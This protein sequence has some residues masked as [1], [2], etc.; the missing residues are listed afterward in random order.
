[1]PTRRFSR[2][3]D[4]GASRLG[5]DRNSMAMSLHRD[6]LRGDGF[7]KTMMSPTSIHELESRLGDSSLN[8]RRNWMRLTSL[9]TVNLLADDGKKEWV[10]AL[11]SEISE[12]DR[13][14]FLHYFS[15]R[16]L[17]LGIIT[18]A[19]NCDKA[20]AAA[21]AILGMNSS[22]GKVLTSGP[23]HATVNNIS[24]HLYTV[25][26]IVARRY[27]ANNRDDSSRRAALVVRGFKLQ[28]ECEA[29]KKLLQDPGLGDH[30]APV[31]EWG[32]P[33]EWKFHLSASYWLLICLGSGTLLP[34]NKDDSRAM[35]Q[36]QR[37]FTR[38]ESLT[39][40]R[41]RVAGMITWEQYVNGKTVEDTEIMRLMK[42]LIESADLVC[43]TP[44]LAHTEDHLS[45]WKAEQAHGIA[46]DDA[47]SMSR[48]DLYSIWGNTLLPCLLTGDEELAPLDVKSYHDRD[49]DGNMLNRFGNDAKKSALEFLMATGW[50]VYRLGTQ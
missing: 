33:T 7:W 4:F 50:P 39:R 14:P 35:H 12:A 42:Q 23:T 15:K 41:H 27:N 2:D 46:I 6:L 11:M 32:T 49:S 38:Q 10:D 37:S 16:P 20:T 25:S 21:I 44:S 30:A 22:V 28:E 1:M 31:D 8:G 48:G 17:G 5:S 18:A 29:F 34:L 13:S 47:S 9:P 24:A 19:P 36:L 3:L 40:L 45:S 26:R 43:T